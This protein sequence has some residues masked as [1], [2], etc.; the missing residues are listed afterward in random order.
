M[1]GEI[2]L[3]CCEVC[4]VSFNSVTIPNSVASSFFFGAIFSRC[5][6]NRS[7]SIDIPLACSTPRLHIMGHIAY[8]K[9]EPCQMSPTRGEKKTPPKPNASHTP[10]IKAFNAWLHSGHQSVSHRQT[11]RHVHMSTQKW[12]FAG[13]KKVSISMPIG[14]GIRL[15]W[16]QS[17]LVTQD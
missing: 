13:E 7:H 17:V 1:Y 11:R 3:L 12:A 10:E 16:C 9:P 4:F 5:R 15:F 2:N 14:T 6:P 8:M